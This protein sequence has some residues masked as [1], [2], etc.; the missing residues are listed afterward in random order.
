M[1][2]EADENARKRTVLVTGGNRGIGL[3]TCKEFARRGLHVY[4]TSRG[5]DG[6]QEVER[7]KR[8]GASIEHLPLDVSSIESI[9][10]LEETMSLRGIVLD[11]L[12]N[13]A[14]IALDGFNARVARQTI[15]A[16]FLGAMRVTDALLPLIQDGGTIV[17]VS[18]VMGEISS[19]SQELQRKF[20]SPTLTRPQL[21]ELAEAFVRDV[22]AGQHT[23]RGWP[24]SAYRVSKICM[25]A[26]T[27]V[28]SHEVAPRHIRIN[29][30][31]PGWVRSD[32]GGRGAPRTLAD[33][34][35]SILATALATDGTSGGFFRDGRALAW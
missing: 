34:A 7:L 20:L 2:S 19:V 8:Q 6:V 16:N 5:P 26:L 12:I 10:S 4:L 31:C 24:S 9:A 17:M 3:E 22:D 32:M 27:R 33:G 21:L 25:N 28:M 35:A 1:T 29:S 11:F 23:Q 14:G 18:S 30:V 15:D 13:N